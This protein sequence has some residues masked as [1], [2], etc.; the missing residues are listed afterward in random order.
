MKEYKKTAT[1]AGAEPWNMKD[2][3]KYL[4]QWISCNTKQSWPLPPVL[5]WVTEARCDVGPVLPLPGEWKSFAPGPPVAVAYNPQ[6]K[7]VFTKTAEVVLPP[8]DD[9][10]VLEEVDPS[11]EEEKV[12]LLGC[13]KCCWSRLGRKQC[14][15][16]NFRGKRARPHVPPR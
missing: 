13:A 16:P 12:F 11:G 14:K 1:A 4:L 7:R 2:A 9:G 10:V 15:R 6:R 5:G 8:P 3:E